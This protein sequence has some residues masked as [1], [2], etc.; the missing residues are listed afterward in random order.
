LVL[1][2]AHNK[3]IKS[4]ATLTGMLRSYLAAHPL[5]WRYIRVQRFENSMKKLLLVITITAIT[6]QV[7]AY[8]KGLI[9]ITYLSKNGSLEIEESEKFKESDLELLLGYLVSQFNVDRPK[10]VYEEPTPYARG[11]G[12]DNKSYPRIRVLRENLIFQNGIFYY[13]RAQDPIT[14]MMEQYAAVIG[15]IVVVKCKGQDE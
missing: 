11:L 15:G 13:E 10:T 9:C 14:G 5:C 8:N 7:S 6:F 2:N 1:V 4:F 3:N 12:I